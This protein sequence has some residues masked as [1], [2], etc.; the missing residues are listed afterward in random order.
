MVTISTNPMSGDRRRI[1]SG[2]FP[3]WRVSIAMPP[4][5][6]LD[7]NVA[8]EIQLGA[9]LNWRNNQLTECLPIQWATTD[10]G[11]A[12]VSDTGCV[13]GLSDGDVT[14]VATCGGTASMTHVSI[15]GFGGDIIPQERA[16]TSLRKRWL[17]YFMS[18]PYATP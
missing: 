17:D 15:V 8:P 7:A 18:A 11:K 3:A 5:V 9:A 16:R 12:I 14:I 6:V 13:M 2:T 4:S 10:P 1:S